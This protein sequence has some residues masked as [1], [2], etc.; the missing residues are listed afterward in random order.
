VYIGFG[1]VIVGDP[2]EIIKQIIE[3]VI[4]AG[5]FCVFSSGW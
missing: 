1:S 2:E 5:V 4:K 3:A